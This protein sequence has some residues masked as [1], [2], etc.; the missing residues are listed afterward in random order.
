MFTNALKAIALTGA[1]IVG[2]FAA[3]TAPAEAGGRLSLELSGPGFYFNSDRRHHFRDRA[4][5]RNHCSPRKAVHKARRKG[6]RR[7]HV[8]RIGR[9]GVVVAGRK[10]GERIVMGFSRNRHCSVRFVRARR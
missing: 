6:L 4:H 9:R 7:A 10:W 2:G 1:L 5:R 8:V 3:T